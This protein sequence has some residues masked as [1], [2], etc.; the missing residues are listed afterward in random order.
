M[1]P[2]RGREEEGFWVSGLT[3]YVRQCWREGGGRR[4]DLS[5]VD[6]ACIRPESVRLGKRRTAAGEARTIQ[7]CEAGGLPPSPYSRGEPKSG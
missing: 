2:E 1:C 4:G 7:D 6:T 3:G 5:G